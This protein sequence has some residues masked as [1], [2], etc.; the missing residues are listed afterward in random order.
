MVNVRLTAVVL[1]VRKQFLSIY[2]CTFSALLKL[3]YKVFLS[4][5]GGWVADT[6]IRNNKIKQLIS[7]GNRPNTFSYVFMV[8]W[9]SL[10]NQL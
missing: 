7:N 6:K 8:L 5:I 9:N 4:R 10:N 1:C 2:N 3:M